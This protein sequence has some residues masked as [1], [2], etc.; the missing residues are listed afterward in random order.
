[1]WSSATANHRNS[2]TARNSG[3]HAICRPPRAVAD[4]SQP[5]IAAGRA[6]M[7]DGFALSF[8]TIADL[9][10]LPMSQ[11]PHTSILYFMHAQLTEQAATRGEAPD[12]L[13]S[14]RRSVA[15]P[16]TLRPH[17]H[18]VLSLVGK[19]GRR[20]PDHA[21]PS[22][23]RARTVAQTNA[24]A[25]RPCEWPANSGI[26]LRNPTAR[27]QDNLIRKFACVSYGD[28]PIAADAPQSRC[29]SNSVGVRCNLGGVTA[30]RRVCCVRAAVLA[31]LRN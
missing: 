15:T 14:A 29:Y 19:A 25:R 17:R 23:T 10:A 18:D 16:R 24:A 21:Q 22:R 6:Y 28:I 8:G 30:Y 3:R 5:G 12:W 31:D 27:R 2:R 26:P 13:S 20:R 11:A 9:L 4:V 7:S 1:M